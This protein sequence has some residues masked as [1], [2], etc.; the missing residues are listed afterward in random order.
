MNKTS[1]IFLFVLI[2]LCL[3]LCLS[4]YLK[5]PKIV[6]VRSQEL[7]YAYEGTKEAQT[8]YTQQKESWQANVDTLKMSFQK[9]VASYNANYSR[10]NNTERAEQERLLATQETQLQQY[11]GAIDQKSKMQDDEMMQNVLN[12]INSFSEAYGKEHGYDVILGTTSSGNVLYGKK[13]LD[14][15]EEILKALNKKYQGE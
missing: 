3:G 14:I 12:Q 10:M 8:K 11:I 9:A 13:S 15:T 2:A 1:Q 4:V 7:V 5:Q 6:F